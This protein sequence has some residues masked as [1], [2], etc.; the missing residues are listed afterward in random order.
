M[1]MVMPEDDDHENV[2]AD[3]LEMPPDRRGHRR[4]AS[5]NPAEMGG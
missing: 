3:H 2:E 1:E 4:N 5:G